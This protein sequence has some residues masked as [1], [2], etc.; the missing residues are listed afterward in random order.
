MPRARAALD[1]LEVVSFNAELWDRHRAERARLEAE[2]HELRAAQLEAARSRPGKAGARRG[3]RPRGRARERGSAA[4]PATTLGWALMVVA[5]LALVLLPHGPLPRVLL[6][7]LLGA[8]AVRVVVG[9]ARAR[10][11]RTRPR[12]E[13]TVRHV[14]R[15]GIAV[16]CRPSG[17]VS[18]CRTHAALPEAPV[19]ARRGTRG[20]HL[21]VVPHVIPARTSEELF[22]AGAV[23][24]PGAGWFCSNTCARQYT[25]RFRV[26]PPRPPQAL[27]NRRTRSVDGG[28]LGGRL[29]LGMLA[30]TAASCSSRRSIQSVV[31]VIWITVRSGV[32][33]ISPS[34][35]NS[36][37]MIA[38]KK[39]SSAGFA[40]TARRI[41]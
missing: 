1:T 12:D 31:T 21:S 28:R 11:R 15:V 26:Q 29:G 24:D 37:P 14:S 34:S 18:R 6:A 5:L 13:S 39:R 8:V 4:G 33:T 16:P 20:H 36:A 25:V 10:A 32:A 9:W 35:P 27:A 40:S 3:D 17:R 2:Q 19:G 30:R 7:V 23:L 41:T 38:W 22:L